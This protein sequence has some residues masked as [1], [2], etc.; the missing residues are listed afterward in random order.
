MNKIT[1][2]NLHCR[3]LSLILLVFFMSGCVSVPLTSANYDSEAKKFSVPADKSY[4]YVVR[5]SGGPGT[6]V[7]MSVALDGN[8]VGILATSTFLLLEVSPGKHSIKTGLSRSATVLGYER[9]TTVEVL[10]RPGQHYII[11]S[12]FGAWA[13]SIVKIVQGDEGKKLITDSSRAC[14]L[15]DNPATCH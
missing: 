4:I 8:D 6:G 13:P 5:S 12:M 3:N 11:S 2:S 14:M 15:H 1:L 7:H 10:T 9:P